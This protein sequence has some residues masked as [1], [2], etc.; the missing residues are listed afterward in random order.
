MVCFIFFNVILGSFIVFYL[1]IYFFSIFMVCF[2][3]FNVILG[4]FIV[5]LFVHIFFSVFS[6]YVSYFL[7]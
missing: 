3:F 5:F 2:I 7:M 6:W 1:F 4:S